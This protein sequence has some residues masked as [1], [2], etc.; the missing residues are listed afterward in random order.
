[1]NPN[2]VKVGMR[3]RFHPIIGLKHDGQI[4]TV[5]S[6]G[7]LGHGQNVAWLNG[8]SG[9]VSL[10]A[11]SPAEPPPSDAGDYATP[12]PE[13]SATGQHYRTCSQSE[14]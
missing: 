8:K 7:C 11:I 6:T 10:L 1:M 9:C 13:C 4:Y 12:C 3:V 5:R 14:D 2:E